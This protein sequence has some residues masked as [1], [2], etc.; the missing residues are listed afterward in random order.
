MLGGSALLGVE[1]VKRV[2][3]DAVRLLIAL[4]HRPVTF[5]HR[6]ATLQTGNQSR[7]R[8]VHFEIRIARIIHFRHL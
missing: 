4:E 6:E 2:G 7:A 5:N 3:S 8:L 1:A